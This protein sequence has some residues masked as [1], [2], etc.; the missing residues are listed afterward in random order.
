MD[1]RNFD[2]NRY[3][4]WKIDQFREDFAKFEYTLQNIEKIREHLRNFA[5]FRDGFRKTS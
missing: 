2:Q 1:Q 4:Q 3:N 5:L